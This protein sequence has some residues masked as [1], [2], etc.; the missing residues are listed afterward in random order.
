MAIVTVVTLSVLVAFMYGA[1]RAVTWLRANGSQHIG[2]LTSAAGAFV[3]TVGSAMPAFA[4]ETTPSLSFDLT[5]FF[6]SLNT[7]LPIF[8]GIFAIVGGIAGAMALAKMVINA[9]V[10]AF[11]GGT[12]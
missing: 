2:K 10:N 4:Q 12:M 1:F 11:K 8:I 9:V 3:V 6:D 5:P 7:Y